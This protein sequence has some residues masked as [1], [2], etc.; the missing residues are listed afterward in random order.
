MQDQ[1]PTE[2]ST[3]EP[4]LLRL[5][6]KDNVAAVTAAVD[7]GQKLDLE[8]LHILATDTVPT[9][10]KIAIAEI[11]TG[12]KVIKYGVP[13]GSATCRIQP[14]QYVHTHNLKSDYLP[15]YTL[16]GKNAYLNCNEE[17]AE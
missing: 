12:E 5:H 7:P 9:G 6:A 1:Q 4:H 10:H 15:T 2:T 17:A 14:G 11:A 16:D 13:I 3:T 8:D